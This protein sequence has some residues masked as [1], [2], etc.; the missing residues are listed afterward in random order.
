MNYSLKPPL[1]SSLLQVGG[2][3]LLRCPR[4]A[5]R[6]YTGHRWVLMRVLAVLLEDQR[7]IAMTELFPLPLVQAL[8]TGL[9]RT[10]ISV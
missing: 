2:C 4:G 5:Y 8:Q 1:K 6:T 3:L 9:K 10:Q 7:H